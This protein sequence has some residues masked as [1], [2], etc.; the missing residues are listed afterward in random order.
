[1]GAW[2][3][4]I[5]KPVHESASPPQSNYRMRTEAY[6]D[7]FFVQ[8]GAAPLTMFVCIG[9]VDGYCSYLW[10]NLHKRVYYV[11]LSNGGKANA[12]VMSN[13]VANI[14]DAHERD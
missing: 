14:L 7:G 1:M 6:D 11:V 8:P 9:E 12:S 4:C 2:R 5:G 10:V 13:L 3:Y